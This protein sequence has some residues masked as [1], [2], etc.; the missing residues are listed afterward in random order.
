L[1][2]QVWYFLQIVVLWLVMPYSMNWYQHF[3][4]RWLNFQPG[5]SAN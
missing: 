5:M 4:E 3:R 2:R 1:Y